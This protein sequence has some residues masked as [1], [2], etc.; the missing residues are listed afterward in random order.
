VIQTESTSSRTLR[1]ATAL[2]VAV[3][4]ILVGLAGCASPPSSGTDPVHNG[5]SQT[6]LASWYSD[7]LHGRPT[8]SGEPYDRDALTAAHRILPFGTTV[9]V[10]RLDAGQSVM[11]TINDR[12]PF[13]EGR[14][15]DLSRRA[16]EELDMIHDGVVRVRVVVVD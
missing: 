10:T 12:G 11:V 16:A 15:I 8:A 14:I 9:Q 4:C 2:S 13:V 7:S 5:A 3:C 1:S 6:G